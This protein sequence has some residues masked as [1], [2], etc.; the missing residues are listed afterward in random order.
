MRYKRYGLYHDFS[1]K[2][3]R[4]DALACAAALVAAGVQPGERV[5]LISENRLEWLIADLG[6]AAA[7]G[8]NVSPHAPLTASQIHYQLADAGATW[9]FISTREQL[10]KL[11]QV[12]G[13]LPAIRGVVVFDSEVS[14]ADAVAWP[15][16]IAA[17]RAALPACHGELLR[18]EQRIGRDDLATIMYTSGTTG[19]PKGVMLT[20]GNLLSNAFAVLEVFP[21]QADT[22][23]LN[24]LPLSHIYARTVDHYLSLASGALLCL[25]ES[26]ETLVQN[27]DEVQP[28]SLSSVP[29]FY[30]KLISSLGH[31]SA[32]ETGRRLRRIFGDRI[33]WLGSGGAPLPPALATVYRDAGFPVLQGYGLTESSPVITFNRKEHYKLESVGTPLPGVEVRIAAD[34]EILTRG[35][36]VMKG[37]W[38]QPAATAAAMTDGWLRTGDLGELDGEGFLT[39]TGRKKDLLV[40]SSGK[41]IVPAQIEG[42]LVADPYIDQAVVYGEGRNFLSAV[43]V[44]SIENVQR[45]L[46]AG[47]AKVPLHDNVACDTRARELLAQRIADALCDLAPWER[48]KRFIVRPRAFTIEADEMTVSMKLRRAVILEK[49]RAE[50][51]ALYRE[52]Q[53]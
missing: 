11:R 37:Y 46:S 36:H 50:L 29:R 44:P 52:E 53:G 17:G 8:V 33:D 41:K 9:A 30:E 19:E 51:E 21:M 25:A 26:V 28:T 6:I 48:V 1:W 20:H 10:Q 35:P 38:K 34:G 45:E 23:M 14:E 12:R 4:Q 32:E 16:F 31:A 13:S 18:R 24:W 3:Y 40:L 15:R 49:H 27:I 47:T 42:L 5:G 43:I 7:G 22:I 2:A 39:I